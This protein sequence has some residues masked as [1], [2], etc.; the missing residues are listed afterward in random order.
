MLIQLDGDDGTLTFDGAVCT[1]SYKT[2][3]RADAVKRSL[4]ERKVPV[5]ALSGVE[6]E[7]RESLRLVPRPGADPVIEVADNQLDAKAYPLGL[8]FGKKQADEAGALTEALRAAIAAHGLGEVPAVERPLVPP[9]SPPLEVSGTDG[10]ATFDGTRLTFRWGRLARPEKKGGG[11][12]RIFPLSAVERVEWKHPGG[13]R[14]GHL[15]VHLAG[16]TPVDSKAVADPNTMRLSAGDVGSSL[17][18][19]AAITFALAGVER[20]PDPELLGRRAAPEPE[21]LGRRAAPPEVDE[22]E[23]DRIDEPEEVTALATY[24]VAYKGGHPDLPKAKIGEIR[25]VLTPD[26]FQFNP[27]IG[28]K[29]FWKQL[30]IPYSVINDVT[31]VAR[32]VSTFEGLAGGLDSRQLNQDNNVHVDYLDPSGNEVLLRFEMITGVTVMGQAVKCREF[33]DRMRNLGIRKRFR[34]PQGPSAPAVAAAPAKED[35]LDQLKKLAELRDAGVLSEEE[36]SAK[37]ADLLARL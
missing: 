22:I 32:Q 5:E 23:V 4:G 12:E 31:I 16:G 6:L 1:F 30:T 33:Q 2:G 29:K 28:S 20:Q 15:R 3:L 24:K 10:L 18:L 8:Q 35:V 19:A 7:P 34:Q 14:G 26:S 37:K 36:F 11:P 21:V 27:T 17:A 25:M 13:I 9:P